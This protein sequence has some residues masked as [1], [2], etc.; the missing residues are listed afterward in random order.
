MGWQ[1]T[2][3]AIEGATLVIHQALGHTHG[4]QR[5]KPIWRVRSRFLRL[6]TGTLMGVRALELLLAR[7]WR[8]SG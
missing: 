1:H 3:P 8:R 2:L 7:F 5:N 6:A 4:D